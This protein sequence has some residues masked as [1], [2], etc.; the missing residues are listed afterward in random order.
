M[1]N[2]FACQFLLHFRLLLVETD[3]NV[4]E[5]ESFVVIQFPLTDLSELMINE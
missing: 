3:L 5:S 2:A 4:L 1:G